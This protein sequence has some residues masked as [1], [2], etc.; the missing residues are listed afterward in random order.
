ML[1]G[2]LANTGGSVR[3]C[4]YIR[5]SIFLFLGTFYF[6]L[7]LPPSHRTFSVFTQ[8]WQLS[9]ARTLLADREFIG[10]DWF[11][12]LERHIPFI[13]PKDALG[14][15]WFHLFG[16]FQRLPLG[17]HKV[18]KQRYAIFGIT[19]GVAGARLADGEYIIVVT[20]RNPK[21]ALA[22]YVQIE[23]LFKA[24]KSSGF[25]FEATHLKHLERINTLL[26]VVTLA[27]W[28]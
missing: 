19:L 18:L 6:L 8:G 14:D 12:Y 10:G 1:C 2:D 24:L 4:F 9:Y 21:Q 15:N 3:E 22:S 11:A 20:N 27:L 16:F 23:C 25:D 7:N 28:L 26:A 17:E 13:I 5:Y